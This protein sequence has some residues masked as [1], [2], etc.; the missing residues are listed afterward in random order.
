MDGAATTPARLLYRSRKRTWVVFLVLVILLF[1]LQMAAG[2]GLLG[3]L[4]YRGLDRIRGIPLSESDRAV[5]VRIGDLMEDSAKIDEELRK[6]RDQHGV[7]HLRGRGCAER[8]RGPVRVY[9]EI[10]VT[11]N[12]DWAMQYYYQQER[13]EESRR[14]IDPAG[15]LVPAAQSDLYTWGDESLLYTLTRHDEPAGVIFLARREATVFLLAVSGRKLDDP[16]LLSML[17]GPVLRKLEQY[18]P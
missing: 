18:E 7:V 1:V 10:Q 4:L 9:C 17:L 6:W 2:A 16:Q 3:L 11:A 12:R 8:K 14:Y 13:N 15:E 5:L